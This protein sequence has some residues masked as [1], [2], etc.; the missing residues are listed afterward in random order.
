ME[1]KA[2][3]LSI[4]SPC[5]ENWVNM[6]ATTKGA[7]CQ[8]CQ[9]EV[10]DFTK[11]SDDQIIEFV[12]NHKGSICGKLKNS[13]I[14]PLINPTPTYKFSQPVY[15]KLFVGLFVSTFWNSASLA[16]SSIFESKKLSVFF[17]E[18]QSL[19]SEI[20]EVIKDSALFE[21]L[22]INL[23]NNEPQRNQELYIPAFDKT[24]KTDSN[25]YFNV[26]I[27]DENLLIKQSFSLIYY[28]DI[29]IS[30]VNISITKVEFSNSYMQTEN[31]ITGFVNI[32]KTI[33]KKWWQR[34]QK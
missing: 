11:L 13:Q 25:G 22:L 1:N 27:N 23:L 19:N 16:K 14:D 5:S 30:I 6:L 2:V 7:F 17:T 3:K 10:I 33:K 9:K 12:N 15:Y 32:E 24:I 4:D 26:L 28:N 20:S 18:K 34:K 31:T 8:Q 21:G 29:K